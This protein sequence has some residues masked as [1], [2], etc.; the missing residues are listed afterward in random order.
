MFH[1]NLNAQNYQ[2]YILLPIN[3]TLY[4]YREILGDIAQRQTVQESLAATT[5]EH[6]HTR[7]IMEFK[8]HMW[9][10]LFLLFP[11]DQSVGAE[12]AASDTIISLNPMLPM[13]QIL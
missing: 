13:L 5:A 1:T 9:S 6:Q 8:S 4:F 7:C 10:L 12:P 11:I 2:I 3:I